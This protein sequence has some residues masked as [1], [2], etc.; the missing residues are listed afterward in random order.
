MKFALCMLPRS[1]LPQSVLAGLLLS[2]VGWQAP[3]PAADAA[4]TPSTAA[5]WI[6]EMKASPKGPFYRIRWFCRDGSV[7]PPEP[8]ACREHGGGIQHGEWNAR[9]RALR[10]DGYLIGNVLAAVDP[11]AV[12]ATASGL[13]TLKQIL[14]ERY[15][16]QID[17][18]WIFRG[19][20]NYRG[21]LQ[22]EDETASARAILLALIAAPN[23]TKQR[24][25]LLLQAAKLLPHGQRTPLVAEIRQLSTELADR[26]PGFKSLRAKIHTQPDPGDAQRVRDYAA[27]Q[28][29]A[30]RA[31]EFLNLAALIDQLYTPAD[32]VDTLR[33]TADGLRGSS[34][35]ARLRR[36]ADT[37]ADQPDPWT[38]YQE[39]GALLVFAR[40]HL[41]EAGTAAQQ[42]ALLD[43]CIALEHE[44][45]ASGTELL[46]KLPRIT[47]RGQ[48][49]WLEHA[50][51][52]L[53]GSGLLTS[54]QW[55]AVNSTVNGLIK[56]SP[57]V[58]DYRNQLRYLSRVP[59]W[60]NRWEQFHFGATIERWS[61]IEPLVR[62]FVPDQLLG[63]PLLVYS[64]ALDNL[65]QDANALAGIDNNLFGQAVGAGL[66]AI[67]PGLAHG[68]LR[69]VPP[70]ASTAGLRPDGIYLL[71]ATTATL[72]PVAGI[73][74]QGEG[75]SLSHVQLL[76]RNL[77]IPNV[78]ITPTLVSRLEA[79][80]GQPVILAVSPEGR[81]RLEH[82]STQWN[83]LFSR[84]AAV[85]AQTLSPDLEKLDLSVR[86]LIPLDELRASDAGRLVG[87]KAAN[88]GELKSRFPQNVADGVAIPFGLFRQLLEQPI[89]PGGPSV[90]QWME[91]QYA[92]IRAITDDTLRRQ[93][94]AAVLARMQRWI[95]H[96]DPGATFR[97]ALRQQLE[98]T[99]GPDGS[100]TL[101]V[102]SDTN[103]EDLPGFSG[104]GLNLTV[105][106]VRGFDNILQAISRVWAS[107]F[108][109]RAYNWRQARMD[110]PEQV[111]PS[112]LLMRSV[113]VEKSGVL[114]TMDLETG[115]RNW[116]TVASNEGVGGAV[117]SQ[118]AE[119]LR[120]NSD[121]GE[122]VVLAEA[123]APERRV[124]AADGGLDRI[125]V[126]DA[127]RVLSRDEIAQLVQLVQRLPQQ[128]PLR[129][130]AGRALPADVEFGFLHGRLALFQIRPY[131]E[132]SDARQSTFLIG[133]DQG[134][135]HN[136]RVAVDLGRVPGG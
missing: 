35:A 39:A 56:E 101:Y 10:A 22:S 62:E 43:T 63:S 87:P 38:R 103:V 34:L 33:R 107:P 100:Y 99:F 59:A 82:N 49:Y 29:N 110:Q 42:L 131:V 7:L 108:T 105:P 98:Q 125:P 58:A 36:G 53:Y 55:Q 50:N 74:T 88:L 126:S 123:T 86:R 111:Y 47:R 51:N 119:E 15:L 93:A 85:P 68:V 130:A 75:N 41:S 95:E 91:G 94:A 120:V 83:A 31:A 27:Q 19:A 20:R 2:L 23:N 76:A 73:L 127:A 65:M 48:L 90:F 72:P 4:V 71:P 106:N 11:E 25:M 121:S 77:G 129:D 78:A 104:A 102:R 122:V 28:P 24:F 1:S 134:L 45:F 6:Q 12:T 115:D 70:G 54:R 96:A 37:L 21:A 52:A 81:V 46:E 136:A 3:L 32:I 57:T 112:V 79:K 133:M 16:V 109:E 60:A 97:D 13:T 69:I 67:N 132:R 114:V 80:A 118:A 117:D 64:R 17:N 30:P 135:V 116:F 89:E 26:D 8:Y 66:R 5:A 14:L 128:F 44:A 92:M 61:G 84:T 40:N 124:F 113:P 9:T 18:G